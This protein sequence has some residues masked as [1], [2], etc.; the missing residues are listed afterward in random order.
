MK[1]LS[2]VRLC[3]PVDCSLPGSSVHRI[4]QARILEWVTISFSRGSSRPGDWT[5]VSCIA[6]RH[7][8]LWATRKALKELYLI[9]T[10]ENSLNIPGLMHVT[11]SLGKTWLILLCKYQKTTRP[12]KDTS[13][14]QERTLWQK[15]TCK[16]CNAVLMMVIIKRKPGLW[17]TMY[18]S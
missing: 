10:L 2:H 17:F 13:L 1:L 7:F 3:D 8:N 6:G 14:N 5:Q 15:W 18:N 9:Q 16:S 4:L 12:R 11:L